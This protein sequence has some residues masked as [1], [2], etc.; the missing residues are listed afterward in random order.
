LPDDDKPPSEASL[1][2]WLKEAL[3]RGGLRCEGAGTRESPRRYRLPEVEAKWMADPL[4]R[5]FEE[6]RRAWE[7]LARPDGG[8]PP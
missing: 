6:D 1:R 5:M 3:A 4:Y 8:E 2:R 7:E